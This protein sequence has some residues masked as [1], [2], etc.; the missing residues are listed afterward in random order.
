LKKARDLLYYIIFRREKKQIK[1]HRKK[2]EDRKTK[3]VLNKGVVLNQIRVKI[4]TS[5]GKIR[6][7]SHR[8]FKL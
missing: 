8:I 1:I 3:Q 4:I 2:K 7:K 5:T 6:Y